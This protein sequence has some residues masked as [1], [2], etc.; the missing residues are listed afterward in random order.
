MRLVQQQT[1]LAAEKMEPN[2]YYYYKIKRKLNLYPWFPSCE[3]SIK[4]HNSNE[5]AHPNRTT[6]DG[7]LCR[8]QLQVFCA[9]HIRSAW[10]ERQSGAHHV[11]G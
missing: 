2:D 11:W 8:E 5:I 4:Q 1:I 10:V 7:V 3:A 9:H 6:R